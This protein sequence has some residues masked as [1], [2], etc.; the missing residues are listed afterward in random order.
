MLAERRPTSAPST[1]GDAARPA[2]AA[3]SDRDRDRS[4]LAHLSHYSLGRHVSELLFL[5]RGFI[6]AGLLD[7]ALY[8][9]WTK[10]KIILLLLGYGQLGVH[11]AMLR[12]VPY[13]AG[14]DEGRRVGEIVRNTLGFGLAA[15]LAIAAGI[16]GAAVLWPHASMGRFRTAW[17]LLAPVFVL[18]HL[19]WY[20]HV[21]LRAEKRFS[22]ASR[23]MVVLAAASTLLCSAGAYAFGL[24]GLLAGLGASYLIVFATTGSGGLPFPRPAWNGRALRHLIRIGMPIM[25]S[26]ALV[27]LLWNVDKLA[28]WAFLTPESLGVY[29]LLSYLVLSTTLIPEAVSAVLYPRLM[30][31]LGR[32]PSRSTAEVYFFKPTL[33]IAVIAGPALGILF[34]TMHLPVRWF[35]PKYEAGILPGQVLLAGAYFMAIAR[36]PQM[37][38]VSLDRQRLLLGLT[39]LSV[40]ACAA[41]IAAALTAGWALVG[42]AGATCFGFF[43]YSVVVTCASVRATRVPWGT[44]SPFLTHLLMP[45]LATAAVLALSTSI[46][47]DT[48]TTFVEDLATTLLRCAP[49]FLT[50]FAL[51]WAARKRLGLFGRRAAGG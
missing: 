2:A 24:S 14:R 41:A 7:P 34:L 49:V 32:G 22:G 47:Q 21:K 50:A 44:A 8:G 25:G 31:E 48:P 3:R 42:V 43:F 29:G 4:T 19:Y 12:E 11:E 38:L 26:G 13:A 20:L 17:A 37:L 28:I 1:P 10:M 9:V 33:M 40:A 51:V 5:I 6:L 16:A 30:E 36:I 45:I 15:A 27:T 35:L 23:I 18:T 39:A 46:R